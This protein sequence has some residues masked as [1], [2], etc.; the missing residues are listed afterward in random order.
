MPSLGDLAYPRYGLFG[1]TGVV[2]LMTNA[3]Q[4]TA[5]TPSVDKMAADG[6]VHE[7]AARDWRQWLG[8]VWIGAASPGLSGAGH[9]QS[10][11][12]LQPE[13]SNDERSHC[14]GPCQPPSPASDR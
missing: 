13:E 5:N 6:P 14:G 3:L 8:K 9:K 7:P 1:T 10:I 12:T 11:S 2:H 4:G